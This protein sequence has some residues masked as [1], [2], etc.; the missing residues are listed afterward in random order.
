MN[1][2]SPRRLSRALHRASTG[3]CS[4]VL[5]TPA[6]ALLPWLVWIL[7]AIAI[8]VLVVLLLTGVI[9]S[10]TTAV[11]TADAALPDL[12]IDHPVLEEAAA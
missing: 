12:F 4:I 11:C 3:R 2:P 8:I 5:R 6:A 10:D 9:G 1:S 7:I